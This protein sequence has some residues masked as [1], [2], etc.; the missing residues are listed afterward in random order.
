MKNHIVPV[1]DTIT[2]LEKGGMKN[3]DRGFNWKK[4]CDRALK[5]QYYRSIQL[6]RTNSDYQVKY[7][8]ECRDNP[9]G[10]NIC[11]PEA[12]KRLLEAHEKILR[13]SIVPSVERPKRMNRNG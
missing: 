5:K 11:H 12:K 10:K 13:L 9:D 2:R 1:S 6:A 3:P 7:P 8:N 4:A